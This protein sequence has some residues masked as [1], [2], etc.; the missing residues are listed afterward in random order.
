MY[1]AVSGPRRQIGGRKVMQKSTC[2]ERT[3][4]GRYVLRRLLGRGGMAEVH[5]A[6]D[7]VLARPVAVKMLRADV[8]DATGRERFAREAQA[9]A[10]LSH[11]GIVAVYDVGV[12]SADGLE[13]PYIVMEYVPGHTLH[14]LV[15]S[16]PL[17][18]HRAL[19]LTAGVLDALAHAHE[20]GIIH[21]DI[22]PAN[23]MISADDSVKVM[24]FGIARN[25]FTPGMTLTQTSMVVGTAEYLSPE[26]ARGQQLDARTDL[27]STGCL[28]Y[29]L[30]T[31]HP[32]FTGD[33]PLAIAY[34]HLG[35]EPEPPSA[36]LPKPPAACDNVVLTALAKDP[37]ERYAT[38]WE[39]LAAI[40]DIRRELGT[41]ASPGQ[42]AHADTVGAAPI[43][44]TSTA[45][46]SPDTRSSNPRREVTAT[47]ETPD[48]ADRSAPRRPSARRRRAF[49]GAILG[50]LLVAGAMWAS[51]GST[52]FP[53]TAG[54]TRST[55]V[56]QY[57]SVQV[58]NLVGRP[59]A[60]ARASARNY[61]LHLVNSGA[62]QCPDGPRASARHICSQIPAPGTRVPH[63][64]QV[65]VRLSQPSEN[66]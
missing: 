42:P 43:P 3:L 58:P 45:G 61:G 23:V 30:L 40:D 63:G 53:N 46:P 5:L 7:L 62:G 35:D 24:D 47:V 20:R 2:Q 18:P 49:F 44:A 54:A 31:G 65:T 55:T 16:G 25:V 52:F 10:S 66:W 41:V 56:D 39:M 38:A 32:P 33:S 60:Q 36:A 15:R 8:L 9:V 34:Q 17:V 13:W 48:A 57:A 29:E 21:R 37:D 64:S 11:P 50:S 1:G 6:D 59:F 51:A 4:G 12:E 28:L 19:R 26:Q 22:K 14:Q 27:Y